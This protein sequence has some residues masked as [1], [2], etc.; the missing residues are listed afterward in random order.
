MIP[1]ILYKS[2]KLVY[3][4]LETKFDEVL[5]SKTKEDLEKW[6]KTQTEPEEESQDDLWIDLMHRMIVE[7]NDYDTLS[8]EFHI[9]RKKP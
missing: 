5:E 8:E 2:G 3:R 4:E 1:T 9:Q 6:V 7:G